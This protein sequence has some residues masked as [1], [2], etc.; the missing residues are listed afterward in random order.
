M[1]TIKLTSVIALLTCCFFYVNAQLCGNAQASFIITQNG[2]TTVLQSNSTA[3]PSG[4]LYQW[5]VDGSAVTSPNPNTAYTLSNLPAGYHNFCLYV[6]ADANTFCDSSCRTEN[7]GCNLH[8]GFQAVVHSD[9][10]ILYTTTSDPNATHHWNFGDGTDT[11]YTSNLSPLNHI[12]PLTTT[13]AVYNVCHYVSL[14]GTSCIDSM[15]QQVTVAGNDPCGNL[16]ANWTQVYNAGGSV[17]FIGNGSINTLPNIWTFGDGTSSTQPEPTHCYANG[18]LYT[19]CHV[20]SLPGSSCADTSCRS[21]QANACNPCVGLSV[22]IVSAGDTVLERH[23]SGGVAPYTYLWSNG[24][25]SNAIHPT[26]PGLYCVTAT[27]ANGCTAAAC[28]SVGNSSP[29]PPCTAY[30][31]W[32]LVDCNKVEF[33]NASQGSGLHYQW[34]FGNGIV[35]TSANP[36]RVFPVGT[37]TVQ[38]TVYNSLTQ[39]QSSYSA[40]ITVQPC[41]G[42]NDTLCGAVF[43]DA[44]S[45]GIWDS[46]EAGL[47]NVTVYVDSAVVHT[48]SFGH[49]RAVVHSGSHYVRI[50]LANGCAVTLPMS[51]NNGI[52]GGLGG[53]YQIPAFTYGGVHCGYNFGVH[54]G[55]VHVCGTV[56]LD[57]NNNHTLDPNETGIPNVI[58]TI[59][60]GNGIAHH[61]YTD[62]YGRYCET[63]PTGT[64]VVTIPAN[65]YPGGVVHPTSVTVN[66][67]NAGATYGGND[68]GV[69]VQPGAC[70]LK[71]EII[72]HTTVTPGFQAWYNVRV[73]NVGAVAT[74]G[75]LDF[76]YDPALTF[77]HSNPTPASQGNSSLSWNVSTLTPGQCRA[78]WLVFN[79]STQLAINQS[80]FELAGITPGANCND[81]NYNNN[82]D[83]VHQGV[84]GSWDPNNKLAYK[85]NHETNTAYQWISAIDA[86]QRL[87]YVINFQNEGNGPAVNVVVKN[88]LTSDLDMSSFQLL[89]TSHPSV[90]NVNGSE[91]SFKFSNIMLSPKDQDEPNSHG[92]VRY[93]I[94]AVNGLPSGHIIAEPADIYFDYNEAVT[95]NDGAVILLD[96]TGIGEVLE[97]VT[98][99]VAP[100]PMSDYTR[101]TLNNSQADNFRFRVIDITGRMVSDESSTGNTLLLNRNSLSSGLYVYQVVQ[102]NEV[103]ATGKLIMQ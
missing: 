68:F 63:L 91:L 78:Y 7:I 38:L 66:A 72:P 52:G 73:C 70:D 94:N 54:C 58:V 65:I 23:I 4:G 26:S 95:T 59:M 99:V 36:H 20:V 53:F 89:G 29:P 13:T 97:A 39:C 86:D 25:T 43:N 30:F 77:D 16:N 55:V 71:V 88:V 28:D 15:C 85:T 75:T 18:G 22:S 32:H 62:Q 5:W 103:V 12:F 80:T 60:G 81:G 9:T 44:N 48:D 74:D 41:G 46:G 3:V 6:F 45:N 69:Y 34:Y 83:T 51:Q 93:A 19:V 40:V 14:P 33:V 100:N 57:A 42:I 98:V 56:Y 11:T 101:I 61:A 49:Y 92:W 64:Y 76:F 87:E 50:V 82:V 21:I 37:W 17:R 24:A 35:D 8:A 90:L 1:K 10:A 96:A 47:P 79:A 102:K 31:S 67:T 2:P 27:D 84:T